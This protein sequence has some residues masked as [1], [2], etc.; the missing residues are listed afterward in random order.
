MST[1]WEVFVRIEIPATLFKRLRKGSNELK[2][3]PYI[4]S[5][6][7][8]DAINGTLYQWFSNENKSKYE[9]IDYTHKDGPS[10]HLYSDSLYIR[11]NDPEE[12][13]DAIKLSIASK[14]SKY[15][16][17]G[18]PEKIKQIFD[19]SGCIQL[20]WYDNSYREPAHIC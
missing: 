9:L 8:G 1:D 10:F 20:N 3:S 11:C 5:M 19:D 16:F 4:A 7:L 18:T 13:S 12:R 6:I 15:G 14:L 2:T 17:N